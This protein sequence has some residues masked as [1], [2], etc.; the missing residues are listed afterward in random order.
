M[1][2]RLTKLEAECLLQAAEEALNHDQ[3]HS[4]FFGDHRTAVRRAMSKIKAY[5][6]DNPNLE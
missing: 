5:L 1:E 2:I 3:M 4:I 6:N